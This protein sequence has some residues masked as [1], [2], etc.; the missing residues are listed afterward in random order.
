M[1]KKYQDLAQK[2]NQLQQQVQRQQIQKLE[3]ET[4]IKKSVKEGIQTL[5]KDELK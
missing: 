3:V 1:T 5:V 4:L 2:F